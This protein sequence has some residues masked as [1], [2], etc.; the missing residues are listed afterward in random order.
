M[1]WTGRHLCPA[2]QSAFELQPATHSFG[3]FS[4]HPAQSLPGP[5][6][7]SLV[8]APPG[9]AGGG[10]FAPAGIESPSTASVT[11]PRK[12]VESERRSASD[13]SRTAGGRWVQRRDF[14]FARST[15]EP[16]AAGGLCRS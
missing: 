2:G 4:V 1:H 11:W 13:C 15:I 7:A 5:Q 3:P 10:R 16:I 12:A 8:H 14:T 9:A 6:S